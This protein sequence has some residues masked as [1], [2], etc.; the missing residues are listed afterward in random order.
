M[1][2]FGSIQKVKIL[3][4]QLKL[5]KGICLIITNR[6]FSSKNVFK[7]SYKS[8]RKVK[9]PREKCSKCTNKKFIVKN[10]IQMAKDTLKMYMFNRNFKMRFFLLVRELNIKNLIMSGVGR[11]VEKAGFSDTADRVCVDGTIGKDSLAVFIRTKNA[12]CV[13]LLHTSRRRTLAKGI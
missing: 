1:Q 7:I 3:K 11:A 5:G 8:V 4:R 13:T 10:K 2:N 9:R 6:R 12:V